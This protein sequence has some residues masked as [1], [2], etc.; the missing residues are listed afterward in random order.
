VKA[1]KGDETSMCVVYGSKAALCAWPR[2]TQLASLRNKSLTRS[3]FQLPKFVTFAKERAAKA[4]K[5][6]ETSASLPNSS[7]LR[8]RGVEIEHNSVDAQQIT[9]KKQLAIA[10]VC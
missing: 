1:I 8:V 6:A 7:K 10:K 4:I 3:G 9:H 5:G 2:H